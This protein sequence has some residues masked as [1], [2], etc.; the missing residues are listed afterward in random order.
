MGHSDSYAHLH[1]NSKG[2][3]YNRYPKGQCCIFTGWHKYYTGSIPYLGARKETVAF[4]SI[5]RQC[6]N[7]YRRL[8]L[9][10]NIH[11]TAESYQIIGARF[12]KA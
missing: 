4:D 6:N 8:A 12:A 11:I 7:Y 5:A 2:L 9:S 10:D 3:G 1:S